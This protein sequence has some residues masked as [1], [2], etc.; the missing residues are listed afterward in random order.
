MKKILF[1]SLVFAAACNK[2]AATKPNVAEIMVTS[3]VPKA[4]CKAPEAVSL[5]TLENKSILISVKDGENPWKVFPYF[6]P[7]KAAG[8]G[9]GSGSATPPALGSGSGSGSAGK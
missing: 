6:E 9:S 5:C 1:V 8:S 2:P 3:Q 4:K 7:E